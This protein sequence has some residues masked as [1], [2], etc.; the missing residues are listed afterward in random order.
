M[1]IVLSATATTTGGAVSFS[2][3][4]HV[5]A[6]TNETETETNSPLP[7][8]EDTIQVIPESLDEIDDNGD[9]D[10][11]KS[12]EQTI[13]EKEPLNSDLDSNNDSQNNTDDSDQDVQGSEDSQ[14]DGDCLFDPDLPKC[15]PDENGDC[16]DGFFQNEDGQCVPGGGCPEGYHSVDNDESGRCIPD[17]EGCPEDMIF[18][19][20]METCGEKDDVCRQYPN[21][22]DCKTNDGS[23]NNNQTNSDSDAYESGYSHGCSDAKI[24]DETKRHINQPGKGP[25]NHTSEFMEGYQDGFENCSTDPGGQNPVA[26]AGPDKTVTAGQS[27]TLD[28]TD[29][30]DPDG[31]IVKYEWSLAE[32]FAPGCSDVMLYNKDSPVALLST[33]SSISEQCD[34]YYELEVTDNDGKTSSSQDMVTITVKPGDSIPENQ[35]PVANAGNDKV[36]F[37]GQSVTLDGSKSYDPDGEIVNYDWSFEEEG[38][39]DCPYHIGSLDDDNSPTPKFTAIDQVPKECSELW[40][41]EVT[42]NQDATSGDYMSITVKPTSNQSGE[43]VMSDIHTNDFN[44]EVGDEFTI[45]ATIEN[46]MDTPIEYSSP[47]CGEETLDIELDKEIEH[48]DVVVCQAVQEFT[49]GPHEDAVV[50]SGIPKFIATSEGNFNAQVTF[51][52]TVGDISD[53]IT[54][55][56]SFEILP[57]QLQAQ[58]SDNIGTSDD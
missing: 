43:V 49:L 24:L 45:D 15:A 23:N 31:Q 6:Q 33:S 17:S 5:F 18:R 4:G 27:T 21:L 9:D 1:C 36:L 46:L 42:D 30:Y 12:E 52:Y 8:N 54:E 13:L 38:D 40:E 44:V 53:E 29:S 50:S 51:D 55:S 34:S 20:D 16:P 47:D 22:E 3:N 35:E 57:G 41:L 28:G 37:E 19:P 26:D 10:K 2:T 25:D 7:S 14:P 32:S 11:N 56:F 48:E 58:P 39:S